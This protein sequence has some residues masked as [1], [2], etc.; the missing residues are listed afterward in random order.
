MRPSPTPFLPVTADIDDEALESLARDKGVGALVKPE[1]AQR[2]AIEPA[3]RPDGI[4]SPGTA[5]P[6]PRHRMKPI[7]IE[8]PDYAWTELKIRAAR[9]QVSVRHIIMTALKQQG[10]PIADID[11]VEDGR[12]LR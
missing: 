6:T 11:L 4:A 8:L 5:A 3:R 2:A 12:R 7:N 10:I 1:R 9:A